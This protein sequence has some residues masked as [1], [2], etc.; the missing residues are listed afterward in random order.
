L[1]DFLVLPLCILITAV[2]IFS[3]RSK[4][5]TTPQLAPPTVTTSVLPPEAGFEEGAILLGLD[6][7]ARLNTYDGSPHVVVA[8]V[9]QLSQSEHFERLI[10][11]ELGIRSLLKC[12]SIFPD[13]PAPRQFVIQPGQSVDYRLNRHQGTRFVGIV[14]G[15]NSLSKESSTRVFEI[16]VIQVNTGNPNQPVLFKLD[17]L[18]IKLPLGP[19]GIE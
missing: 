10:R 13:S 9:Y 16:P 5:T 15:F 17:H 11:D 8:C 2:G 1:K 12:E 4:P 6:A 3:C 7:D 19:Q 18:H 14:V